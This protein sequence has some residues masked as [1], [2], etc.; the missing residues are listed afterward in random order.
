MWEYAREQITREIGAVSD[1]GEKWDKWTLVVPILRRFIL[2]SADVWL[3]VPAAWDA[4]G[5]DMMR[6]A[7]ITAG[8]VRSIGARDR[9]WR[10][11]LHIITYGCPLALFSCWVLTHC[12]F[13]EPEAAAVHC[14][15][16]TDLHRLKPSQIF[17]ICDAG[18][19]TVVRFTP[20]PL[21]V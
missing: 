13:S 12:N 8:L 10:D 9:D 18:G 19:G 11:R 15:H 5:C 6:E 21:L 20:S 1:L 16:L 17:M 4:R 7:A 2:D 3:T 14:A